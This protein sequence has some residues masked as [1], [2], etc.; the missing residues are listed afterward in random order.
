MTQNSPKKFVNLHN[1]SFY[2]ILESNMSPEH[3]LECA[4]KNN[5]PAVALTDSG[6]AY[7]LIEF[8]QSAADF[9]GIKPILGVEVSVAKDSRFERRAGIDGREGNLVLLAKN[10]K[11]YENLLKIV[12]QAWLDGFYHKARADWDILSECSEGLI[13]LTSG[14]GGLIGKNLQNFGE[15]RAIESFEKTR[16][17]FGAEN[18][19][20][21]FIARDYPQQTELNKFLLT[22]TK[23]YSANTVVTSDARYENP[24]DEEAVDTLFC[25]HRNQQVD[26]PNRFKMAEKNWFKTWEEMTEILNYIPEELLEK[27][28]G[29]SLQIAEEINC[30]VGFRR[31]LLPHFEVSQGETE[32]SQ[33]RKNCVENVEKL[34]GEKLEEDVKFREII[35]KRLDYELSIIGKMGFDAYFLIVQDFIDFAKENDIAVGPGRGSAAGSIVSYLLGITSIDPIEYELLFERFLNPERISMPDIDIDFSD[36]RREEVFQYVIEKY[37]TEKVSKVCTFGTLSAKAALKDVG[38]AQGVPY[39]EM[40]AFTKLLP[41]KPGFKLADAIEVMD[42]KTMVGAK[43]HLKK[44]YEVAKKV[45]GCVR[46]VSVHAC[47]VIIGKDDLSKYTPLQWAPGAEEIKITQFP[48]QRL[49]DIGLLK[50]DFLGLKNLSILEKAIGLIKITTGE[51]LDLQKIPID[52]KKTFEMFARGETTGVFQFESAGMRRYLKELQP[53]EF[54][55]LVAMNALYRP[56]PMEYIPDYIKGKHDPKSVKYVDKVL[57]PLLKKTYGIAVYQEQI[58]KI[59]QIFAGFSL[60]QADILRKAIGKK[61]VKLLAE[62]RLKFIDGALANGY[63]KKLAVKI[64]DDI[65]VPFSGYGFNRS[66]AV[67]YSRIAYETAYL[68]ANYPVEFMAAMMT[69][70]RNNTDR[71]V[72]EMSEC[73]T[74]EIEVLPPSI[75]ESF[76]HFTVVAKPL[77]HL[78]GGNTQSLFSEKKPHLSPLLEGEGDKRE[79]PAKKTNLDS[80]SPDKGMEGV[81]S[82]IRFGLTAIKGLGEETVDQIIMERKNGPFESLQD[83]A[84]RVNPRLI[85]KKT[86][87]ALAFSGGFDEFGDRRAI[88]DSLD[89]LAIF[90]KE[91]HEKK[92]AGQ[93]GLFGGVDESAVDFVLRDTV[94]T[95]KDILFW[96]RESLGMYVSDHPLKGLSKYFAKFGQLIGKLGEE[97]V[98]KKQTIHG[99]VTD[100]RKIVTK[101]G[102]NMAIIT[103]EDTS[104]KIELP[105]F[106]FRYDK[107]PAKAMEKDAFIRVK[108]KVE[109]RDGNFNIIPDEIKVGDLE[110]IQRVHRFEEELNPLA[111]L[112]GGTDKQNMVESFVIEIPAKSLKSQIN[113]LK[114][115][116]KDN[117]SGDGKAQK[118]ELI[119]N[120]QKKE[121]PFKVLFTKKLKEELKHVF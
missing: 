106:P 24:E 79:N 10:L 55:D 47:A 52:D 63:T 73:N 95:K 82:K 120:H 46:H 85:N 29:N 21:E 12:S 114:D 27:S 23:K 68:R 111:P 20:I 18:V 38:R 5:C 28:R 119:F 42:F 89:D 64:F 40:N 60:G 7:G 78:S 2:S 62:Q 88:V 8:Y 75:N 110:K 107:T 104:G 84:K 53:T 58:L 101:A 97:H 3:L 121:V 51:T 48:Y 103:I 115:L 71:I 56:G 9:A 19:F 94:A 36:E 83:F 30:E 41:T 81:L 74:M 57:E 1:H 108:G 116:L 100:V 31:N 50:M 45:E 105:I 16:E 14:T 80:V 87:E 77:D 96:E 93:M 90:A 118:V 37:G 98:G 44:V 34:Y 112:S 39:G 25:I 61:K 54:E 66:H 91:Y 76:S 22:L 4:K 33:L 26:D 17:I 99:L 11:G 65:I 102:K 49:E 32:A 67:C 113:N 92:E 117:E 43:P 109:E 72:L 35:E 70:D 59:A 13:V 6:G 69:T 15:K 86:L